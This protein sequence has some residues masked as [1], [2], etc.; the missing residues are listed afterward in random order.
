MSATI[1]QRAQGYGPT[2]VQ[3]T[4]AV[5]DHVIFDG[6]VPTVD[7][8]LP[9]L[10]EE[11]TPELGVDS[12]SWQIYQYF[13]GQ[14]SMVVTVKNGTMLMCGTFYSLS[15]DP[16]NV[17]ALFFHHKEQGISTG[18]PLTDV[19]INSAAQIPP[20]DPDTAGQWIWKLVGGSTLSCQINIT[21]QPPN[22]GDEWR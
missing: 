1:I 12:W 19:V 10:P 6:T 13:N 20:R 17:R 22:I 9:L 3:V 8:P 15:Q 2:P 21:L 14:Q 11:W 5:D 16:G 18:D 4:V 7:Q